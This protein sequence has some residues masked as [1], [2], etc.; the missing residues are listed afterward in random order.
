[1][2]FPGKQYIEELKKIM[3]VVIDIYIIK[4]QNYK[5]LWVSESVLAPIHYTPRR[6]N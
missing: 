2:P 1:M 5:V 6:L 4:V 3:K